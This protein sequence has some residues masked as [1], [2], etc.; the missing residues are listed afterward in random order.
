VPLKSQAQAAYLKD[1]NPSVFREFA[2][3]TAKGTKLP[4]K[5]KKKAK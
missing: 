1:H 3:M 4:Y 5:V 2:A